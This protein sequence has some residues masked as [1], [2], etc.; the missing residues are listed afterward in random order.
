[1]NKLQNATQTPSGR[2]LRARIAVA[3]KPLEHTIW[4]TQQQPLPTPKPKSN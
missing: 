4:T 3:M 2:Y 1:M